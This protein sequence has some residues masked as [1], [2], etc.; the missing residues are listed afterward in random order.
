MD[1]ISKYNV[2]NNWGRGVSLGCQCWGHR[3]TIHPVPKPLWCR[4]AALRNRRKR[5]GTSCVADSV[6]I[7]KGFHINC[8]G[9]QGPVW[10]AVSLGAERRSP[11]STFAA[12]RMDRPRFRRWDWVERCWVIHVQQTQGSKGRASSAWV[13]MEHVS[14]PLPNQ[15]FSLRSSW[16]QSSAS[17]ISPWWASAK[18]LER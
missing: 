4:R 3:F 12:P 13:Q 7:S 18:M 8:R 2:K 15:C 9:K 11:L 17:L 14:V 16:A 5:L 10:L 1:V 6:S